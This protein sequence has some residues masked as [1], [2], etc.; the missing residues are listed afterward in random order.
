MVAYLGMLSTWTP[1]EPVAPTLLVQAGEPMPG[2]DRNR[3]WKAT[4]TARHAAV[5]VPATHLT[6]L[7]DRAE[8]TARTIDEWLVRGSGSGENGNRARRRRPRALAR[9]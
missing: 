9:R 3:D 4:W 7:E 8:V 1:G 5:D 6:I 2:V